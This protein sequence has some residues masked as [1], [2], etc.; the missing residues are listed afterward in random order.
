MAV[1]APGLA[2]SCIPRRGA[3]FSAHYSAMGTAPQA[4]K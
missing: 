3:A 4:I 2:T 1:F